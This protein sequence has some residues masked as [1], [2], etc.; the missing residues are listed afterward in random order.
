MAVSISVA[1]IITA[2]ESRLRIPPCTTTTAYTAAEMLAAVQQSVRALYA[3]ARQK[4]GEEYDTLLDTSLVTVAGTSTISLAAIT[5]FGEL[6]RL[7]WRYDTQRLVEFSE[8][9][10]HL[11]EP[12]GFNPRAWAASGMDKP[13]YRLINVNTLQLS[14]CPN[15]IYTLHCWYTAHTPV[16]TAGDTFFGRLDWDRWIELDVCM[17]VAVS[18]KR[19]A[20][21]F[22]ADREMLERDLFSPD[23]KRAPDATQVI[24]DV[25]SAGG[26]R[27]CFD[28]RT[29]DYWNGN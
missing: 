8:T 9:P 21:V 16:A 20:A 25:E 27:G 18:K 14:P 24:R 4:Q 7:A 3:L 1:A 2:V 10:L 29:G 6:H 19:D 26:R 22:V 15:A 12:P 5:N 11:I 13:S 28:R 23:R 17:R